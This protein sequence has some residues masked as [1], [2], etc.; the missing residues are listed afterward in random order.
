MKKKDI[1][2]YF[3][4]MAMLF[5]TLAIM[6]AFFSLKR[7]DKTIVTILTGVTASLLGAFFAIFLFYSL[8]RK[9]KVFISFSEKDKEIA[10]KLKEDLRFFGYKIWSTEDVILPGDVIHEKIK[11]N[12][13]ESD[14]ILLIL[15]MNSI[16]S[17]WI[18]K[19]IQM[20]K[21]MNKKLIPVLI[22]Q[23]DE[24]PEDLKTI[25]LANL[26]KDYQQGFLELK[27]SLR[28]YLRNLQKTEESNL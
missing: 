21:S 14:V 12:I 19:E 9:A 23:I 1:N 6:I 20:A 8:Y 13:N 2:L 18:K 10:A 16:H 25:K 11:E 5:S 22:Q 27:Q 15:S 24:I 17:D 7:F 26:S 28:H 4:W 3:S